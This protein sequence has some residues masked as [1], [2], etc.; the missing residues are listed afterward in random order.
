MTSVEPTVEPAP[1][2]V[3]SDE[4]S[5]AS[6]P[7][8]GLLIIARRPADSL[9]IDDP[10][11]SLRVESTEGQSQLV[12]SSPNGMFRRRTA[13]EFGDGHRLN[14]GPHGQSHGRQGVDV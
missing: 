11:T 6:E 7:C 3:H 4:K 9:Q 1:L 14:N 2:F 8:R 12:H 5:H 10:R 13:R